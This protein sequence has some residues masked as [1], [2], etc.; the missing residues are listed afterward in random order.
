MDV[1]VT[2]HILLD[3]SALNIA[4]LSPYFIKF[5][6][7]PIVNPVL[8]VPLYSPDAIIIVSPLRV[9]SRASFKLMKASSSL[10]PFPLEV[11]LPLTYQVVGPLFVK[12]IVHV[13]VINVPFTPASPISLAVYTTSSPSEAA[14]LS[15]S[16][17]VW[18]KSSWI[19]IGPSYLLIGPEVW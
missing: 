17:N 11:L 7:L 19:S 12:A 18:V 9:L 14:S 10:V 5:K 3:C 4:S 1:A 16:P 15:N 13:V 6:F 8:L 2:V